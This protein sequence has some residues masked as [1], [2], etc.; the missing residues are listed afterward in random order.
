MGRGTNCTVQE[1]E[2]IKKLKN[3]GLSMSQ[4][5]EFMNCSKK[6]VF[7]AVHF[8]PTEEKR[9]R[10]RAT[11]KKFD[12]LL[13][14]ESKKNPFLSSEDLK[15]ALKAPVSSR[16]I[17]N[18]LISAGLKAY[19]A[20]KVPYLSQNNINCRLSFASKHVLRRNWKNVLWSDETKVNLFGS[21]GKVHVRRPK[22]TAYDPKHT[23]KTVKHGGGNIMLWGCFSSSGV[24]PLFWVK[25][26]MCA[27]DYT[28]ILQ[29]VMLPY[30]EEEM[31]LK[32]EFQQDNDPKHSS[33]LAK[34]WFQDNNVHLLE[35]PSQSPDLNPIEHLWGILKK[36]IAGYKPKNKA[37]LWEKVQAEWYNIDPLVCARLVDSMG[38]RCTEVLKNKGGTTK[39]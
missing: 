21:D 32:W 26:K 18:R 36:K 15:N 30:A 27:V 28:N 6:K 12:Q 31:P 10:K 23:L 38:R 34:K 25:D 8:K 22:N 24:G 35:W 39:Y 16:T 20:R 13:I 3:D 17:R 11:S 29:N 19:S 4:I 33:K 1:R 7:S 37:D 2:I 5:A 9:G 14:R